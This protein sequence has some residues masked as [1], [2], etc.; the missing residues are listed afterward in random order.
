MPPWSGSW[1][2]ALLVVTIPFSLVLRV[3]LDLPR[4]VALS[5]RRLPIW[6]NCASIAVVTA[7]VAVFIRF[8]Y[9]NRNHT[10]ASTLTGFLV[11]LIVYAIVFVLLLRQFAGLYPEYL[12]TTGRTGLGL[13]KTTY[14][15]IRDV[16]ELS[17]QGG[18]TSLRIL[19]DSGQILPLDLPARDIDL[20]RKQI[21]ECES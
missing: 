9:Y 12:V 5:H 2:L 15:R 14:R 10:T 21:S 3:L 11:I 13:R 20:L 18:E 16:Q 17:T 4:P 19:T 7:A 1:I 6:L 8:N